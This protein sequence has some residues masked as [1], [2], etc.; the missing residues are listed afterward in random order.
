MSNYFNSLLAKEKG[1]FFME[2]LWSRFFSVIERVREE[3]KSN[4]IGEVSCSIKFFIQQAK[5]FI[6][7]II[8]LSY[9]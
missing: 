6:P 1:V 5:K 7:E 3:L 2:D 4:S 9:E 8:H